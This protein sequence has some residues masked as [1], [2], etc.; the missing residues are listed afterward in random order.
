MWWVF[1]DLRWRPE[2]TGATD[3]E[4]MEKESQVRWLEEDPFLLFLKK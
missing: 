2:V 4:F 3:E 1:D